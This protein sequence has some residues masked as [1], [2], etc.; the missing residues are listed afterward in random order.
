MTQREIRQMTTQ[1]IVR[2]SDEFKNMGKE[3]ERV[4]AKIHQ[5][6][7]TN[8]YRIMRHNNTLFW[9]RIDEPGVAQLFTINADKPLMFLRNF[10]EFC[11]AMEA[12]RFREVYGI[13]ENPQMLEMLKR[14]GYP[15]TVERLP[16]LPDGTPQYKGT[17]NV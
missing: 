5:S 7:K 8:R 16:D 13:T 11:K 6:L 15:T 17:V 2:N 3:W 1:E 4:Y 9:Y 10:K 14:S 12:A